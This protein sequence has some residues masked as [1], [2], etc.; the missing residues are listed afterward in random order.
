M[1][2]SEMTPVTFSSL[3]LVF[4]VSEAKEVEIVRQSLSLALFAYLHIME[5][6]PC[7]NIENQQPEVR[8][9]GQK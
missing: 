8:S 5:Y 2:V 4:T 7:S 6:I 9:G 3:P 1:Y